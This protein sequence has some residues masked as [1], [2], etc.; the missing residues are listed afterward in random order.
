MKFMKITIG[1]LG[2]VAMVAI[3]AAVSAAPLSPVDSFDYKTNTTY[4]QSNPIGEDSSQITHN[5]W[6]VSGN[7]HQ[8]V[9]DQT[10]TPGS[11]ADIVQTLLGHTN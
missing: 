8:T 6:Y 10:T 11:R 5:G 1:A 9:T 4:D 3:P 7:Q 2:V